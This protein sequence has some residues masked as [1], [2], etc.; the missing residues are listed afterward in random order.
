MFKIEYTNYKG[1]TFYLDNINI[2]PEA[3]TGIGKVELT[4]VEL[5]PNPASNHVS[6]NG[7]PYSMPYQMLDMSG[8][9]W[10]HGNIESN[11]AIDISQLPIGV[12]LLR[13]EG[14]ELYSYKRFVKF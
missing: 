5:V 12:Y 3:Y 8:K 14:E 4:D 2:N 6:I 1:N 7:L 13:V 10:L 9:L 11:Q